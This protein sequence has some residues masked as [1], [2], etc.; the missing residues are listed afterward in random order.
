MV[1]P[2]DRRVVQHDGRRRHG[3]RALSWW[4]GIAHDRQPAETGDKLAQEFEPLTGK[5]GLLD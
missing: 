1:E 3:S 4:L 2:S 5:L